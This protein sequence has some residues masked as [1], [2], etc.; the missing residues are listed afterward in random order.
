MKKLLT[1][2]TII[3]IV[4]SGCTLQE[5]CEGNIVV[6][7]PLPDITIHL[8]DGE[9]TIDLSNPPVFEHTANKS[10][11]YFTQIIEGVDYIDSNI[12]EEGDSFILVL[13]PREQGIGRIQVEA[14]D[15]CLSDVTEEF[16]VT[17]E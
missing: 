11:G 12:R 5:E 15:G 7:N 4:F 3:T 1:L 8:E 6:E 2:L 13:T 17:V 16:Q 9:H 10:L 14:G